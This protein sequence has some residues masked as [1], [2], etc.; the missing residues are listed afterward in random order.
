MNTSPPR[1]T[2]SDWTIRRLLTWT[3]DDLRERGLESPRLSAELLLGH[4][5]DKT[6]LELLIDLERPLQA[7]EL[8]RFRELLRR[9][10]RG[11][12]TAYLVGQREF[13]GVPI[14]VDAR[15]LIPRPD[16][17]TLVDV[18]LTRTQH[19]ADRGEA[20]DLC[21]GSGCV[22]VAFALARR[23][24]HVSGVDI[25]A[26]A[27]CVARENAA[28][29][30]LGDE[31]TFELGDLFG[32]LTPERRFA[33]IL[34]NPPYIPTDELAQLDVGIRDFEPR[35]ALDGGP[36]GLRLIERIIDEAPSW[37][38]SDGVL[39]IETGHDQ[40]TDVAARFERT[41]FAEVQRQRD[42]GGNP[43]VVSGRWPGGR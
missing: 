24:W 11:E 25:A 3:T 34:A 6:R 28:R 43:R 1:A 14:G 4:V 42:I 27:L 33:L 2:T 19:R 17:E 32:S 13:Y 12:P 16:T 29:N 10:R 38:E 5:L 39:A 21:T 8:D 9:R 41:G 40:T 31:L 22:A 35:L 18:A 30:R 7:P 26:D 36:D 15:V 20:L 37:L 23:G